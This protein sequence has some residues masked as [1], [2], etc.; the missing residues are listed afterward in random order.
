MTQLIANVT[1]FPGDT[2]A[3]RIQAYEAMV[4]NLEDAL[5]NGHIQKYWPLGSPDAPPPHKLAITLQRVRSADF[6]ARLKE[7]GVVLPSDGR[8]IWFIP[9]CLDLLDHVRIEVAEQNWFDT[10]K[11][12]LRRLASTVVAGMRGEKLMGYV[13]PKERQTDGAVNVGY[14]M[15]AVVQVTAHA[16]DGNV[17]DPT[18]Q[19]ERTTIG[20]ANYP[21]QGGYAWVDI[22]PIWRGT[23][24][25]FKALPL[26]PENLATGERPLS[27]Y[28]IFGK[29]AEAAVSKFQAEEVG[30]IYV[31]AREERQAQQD[32]GRLNGYT[33]PK[34]GRGGASTIGLRKAFDAAQ[35]AKAA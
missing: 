9:S 11:P 18:V 10:Q 3:M 7:R 29:A 31:Q 30:P 4:A 12:D 23:I 27:L 6:V 13:P 17:E 32:A 20:Y 5:K 19:I 21:Q 25:A 2:N 35:A 26:E 14:R 34:K 33:P 22:T 8:T 15:R 28:Q 24:N 1:M 16:E